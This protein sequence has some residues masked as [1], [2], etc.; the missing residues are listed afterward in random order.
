MANKYWL[1]FQMLDVPKYAMHA[2]VARPGK[3]TTDEDRV[4]IFDKMVDDI[5]KEA[6]TLTGTKPLMVN[7]NTVRSYMNQTVRLMW[8][9]HDEAV[10]IALALLTSGTIVER[11][12][13]EI[14]E[15]LEKPLSE[16]E[17]LTKYFEEVVTKSWDNG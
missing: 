17:L 5:S 12:W 1:V 4:S 6:E 3:A 11:N 7:F 10:A 9:V 14:K 13:D 16:E 15:E 8:C 2:S